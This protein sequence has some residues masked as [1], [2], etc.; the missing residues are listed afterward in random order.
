MIGLRM[1]LAREEV[2][3][4]KLALCGLVLRKLLGDARVYLARKIVKNSH[5]NEN[6]CAAPVLQFRLAGGQRSVARCW[7]HVRQWVFLGQPVR[8]RP[9]GGLRAAVAGAG[10]GGAPACA[11]PPV[12]AAPL[13][14]PSST[15]PPALAALTAARLVHVSARAGAAA[16]AAPAAAAAKGASPPPAPRATLRLAPRRPL[17]CADA[18][19]VSCRVRALLRCCRKT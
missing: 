2:S 17:S 1:T 15:A 18:A 16:P 3:S 12:A 9:F 7:L 5:A 14:W 13:T 10:V 19:A 11:S 4:A 6:V 8:S